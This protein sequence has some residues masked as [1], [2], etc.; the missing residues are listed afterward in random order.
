MKNTVQYLFLIIG[1]TVMLFSCDTLEE[2]PYSQMSP[3]VFFKTEEHAVASVNACYSWLGFGG[4]YSQNILLM[5]EVGSDNT[6]PGTHYKAER[7]EIDEYYCSPENSITSTLWE[8]CYKVIN[9]C[10]AALEGIPLCGLSSEREAEIMGEPYFL[11]G[12]TYFNLV[13]LFGPVP[14]M[15]V[16]TSDIEAISSKGRDEEEVVYEQIIADLKLASEGLPF[17]SKA[18]KGRAN[19]G[20]AQACLADVYLTLAGTDPASEYWAMTRDLCL[21]IMSSDEY[22]LMDDFAEV[23][24]VEAQSYNR[25]TM[26]AQQNEG[27]DNG[28]LFKGDLGICFFPDEHPDGGWN[29][30]LAEMDFFNSIPDTYRKEFTF[31]TEVELEDGT[32]L[33]YPEWSYPVPHCGKY[34]DRGSHTASNN[35]TDND[36]PIY[37]FSEVLL[38]YAEA[39]NMLSNGPTEEAL[40]ALNKVRSRARGDRVSGIESTDPAMYPDILLSDGYSADAFEEIVLEERRREL[41]WE[42]KRWFDLKRRKLLIEKLIDSKPLVGEHAYRFPIPQADINTNPNLEQ[43]PG[44]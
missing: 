1:T 42:A 36:F 44:Y 32:I 35:Y 28:Y 18:E 3:S 27:L 39:E 4:Y 29:M 20:A 26:F 12:L 6:N 5:V 11:R 38:M 23:F 16:S 37:R 33:S 19:K 13:R 10:N 30:N 24:S 14:L 41:A 22:E 40:S 34:K 9:T 8:Y 17:Q 21:E 43:N 31:M 2:E 15:T 25:E 7:W